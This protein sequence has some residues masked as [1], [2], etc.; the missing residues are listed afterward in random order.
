MRAFWRHCMA[1]LAMAGAVLLAG[2]SA[3]A[4]VLA[5]THPGGAAVMA[6]C[7]AGTHWDNVLHRC[8]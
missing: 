5:A 6:A 8:L 1:S 7:P 4:A 2:G 3:H